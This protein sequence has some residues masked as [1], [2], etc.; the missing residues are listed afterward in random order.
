MLKTIELN[1]QELQ[2]EEAIQ[3][4]MVKKYPPKK[5]TKR[6][7]KDLKFY[8]SRLHRVANPLAKTARKLC[9]NKDCFYSL[10][11]ANEDALNAWADGKSVNITPVMMDFLDTDKELAIV[12][13]HELAHNIMDHISKQSTNI[14]MGSVLDVIAAVSGVNTGGAFG[15]IGGRS[16]SQGFENEADYIGIY[17]MAMAGYDISNVNTLWRKMSVEMPDNIN[18]SFFSTHPSN[19]ERFLRMKKT[20]NEINAKKRAQQPLMPNLIKD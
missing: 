12:V 11:V 20:I 17:I 19:A 14:A 18:A 16:Y 15:A 10:N 4:E 7:H 13:S 6:K 3:Q 9:T 5:I 1:E 2:Q 8:E